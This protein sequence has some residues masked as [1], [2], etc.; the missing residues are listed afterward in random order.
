MEIIETD[1]K[2]KN[3]LGTRAATDYIALHHAA[4]VKCSA[5]DIDRWHKERGWSGIGYHYFV[6]KDGSVYRGR[7][8]NALG[9]HV[10]GKNNVSVGVCV[11]GDYDKER[12]M[13]QA[14]KNAVKALLRELK[15]IYPA[16]KI[17]GHGEIGSSD[18][19]GRYY[20]LEEM[21]NDYMN[22]GE[23]INMEELAKVKA[24]LSALSARLDILGERLGADIAE[25]KKNNEVMVYDYI[26]ENMPQWAHEGVK[27][28]VDNG[29]IQGVGDG[30]L[31]L[32]D[33]DLRYC[34]I[35]MRLL[36]KDD[37]GTT[38]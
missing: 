13:P 21:K 23:E 5:A 16:A 7:P 2:W 4:S 29:I 18:C 3:A 19:P 36:K 27:F 32:D 24:E 22:N 14:Q 17:V 11:E 35:I 8:Q 28:C 12:V 6:R 20:P 10:Q 31:G 30:R 26:D 9:A 25:L 15:K 37:E 33:K 34:T 1:W 38:D